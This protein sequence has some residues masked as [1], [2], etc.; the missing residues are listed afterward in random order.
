MYATLVVSDVSYA[1][2]PGTEPHPVV[3]AASGVTRRVPDQHD[4]MQ[5]AVDAEPGDLV[6]IGP[7][8]YPEEVKVDTPSLVLRGPTATR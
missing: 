5:V 8:V 4:T 6:L 3:A 2:D 7:G 1:G